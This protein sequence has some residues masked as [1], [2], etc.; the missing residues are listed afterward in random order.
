M[1]LYGVRFCLFESLFSFFSFRLILNHIIEVVDCAEGT[2]RQ[3]ALQL[4]KCLESES[5]N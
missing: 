2:L 1:V 4:R 3:F 5:H